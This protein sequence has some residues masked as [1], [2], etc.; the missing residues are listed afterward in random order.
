[1]IDQKMGSEEEIFCTRHGVQLPFRIEQIR[2]GR[3]SQ[4]SRIINRDG[5]WILKKYFQPVGTQRDRLGTEFNFLVFLNGEGLVGIPRPVA[6]DRDVHCALYSFQPGNRPD[7]IAASHISQAASFIGTI[8]RFRELSAALALPFAADACMTWLDHLALT[9]TRISCLIGL[10]P[11]SVVEADALAFITGQLMPIWSSIKE[12]LLQEIPTTQLAKPLSLAERILSPSDFGFHNTLEHEG[13]LSFVDFEYAG[14]D[15]PAKL[16]CDFL[17]QPEL[18]ITV[19]QG[20]QFTDDVLRNWQCADTVMHR[21]DKLLPVHRLKWCCIL[22]NEFRAEDLER[23]LHAGVK[24]NGLLADQLCKAT[25]YFK[26]HLALF[27]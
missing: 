12:G 14:W 26:K 2:A 9:E 19:K 4:V 6:M 13:R 11:N 22:L 7:V 27:N 5:K 3:N 8:N 20:W 18:P 25:S 10:K 23:R 15:D 1:M 17:C 21:V 24:S 16:I